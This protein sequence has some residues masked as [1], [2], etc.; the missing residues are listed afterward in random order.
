MG[1]ILTEKTRKHYL[2]KGTGV[3]KSIEFLFNERKE[4]QPN[5]STYLCLIEAV[6]GKNFTRRSLREAFNKL[7][8]KEDYDAKE[9]WDVFEYIWEANLEINTGSNAL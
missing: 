3:G 2:P 7:V 5:G 9:K 6:R 8:N 1:F 4:K